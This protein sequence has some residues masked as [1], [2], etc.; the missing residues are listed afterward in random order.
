MG[1]TTPEPVSLLAQATPGQYLGVHAILDYGDPREEFAVLRHSCGFF[2]PGWRAKVTVSGKDRVRW[3]HNMV[4][5]NVRDLPLNR[6]N[7]NFVLNAQGRILG[8]IYIY[9]RGESL[10][11]D[12]DLSQVERLL[13]AMKRFII[14]DKVEMSVAS[15]SSLGICGPAAAEVLRASGN[16]TT[17]MEPLELRDLGDELAF[18]R[19]PENKP[20]WYEW[21]LP[22]KE[23]MTAIR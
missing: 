7:Y 23:G 2:H 22:V 15:V 14:M 3:L 11:I 16:D 1:N 18:V 5:N 13:T 10:W 21:W 20:G 19:G 8:D 4:T 6:G 12:T 9:N 17:G